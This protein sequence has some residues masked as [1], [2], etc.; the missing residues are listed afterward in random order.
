MNK[1]RKETW[2]DKRKDDAIMSGNVSKAFELAA[3][4]EDAIGCDIAEWNSDEIVSF[5][6]YYATS[7]IQ[8]LVNLHC[9]L[10]QY[11]DWCVENGLVTDNQNHWREIKTE[12]L[13]RCTD[14]GKVKSEIV[15]RD[16]LLERIK[17]LPNYSDMFI[18]LGLFEGIPF[19]DDCLINANIN[20]LNGNTLALSNGETRE[21][22]DELKRIMLIAS[23]QDKYISMGKFQ[24]EMDYLPIPGQII[25]PYNSKKGFSKKLKIAVTM[26]IRR[27]SEYMGLPEPMKIKELQ[28]SG[29]IDYI[30][31]MMNKYNIT[32][33]Q[34]IKETRYREEHQKIYGKIQNTVTYL[35][36]YG[37][38]VGDN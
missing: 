34:C 23:E 2:L 7:K 16:Q 27:C 30:K 8:S 10:R 9:Q 18:F 36:L 33:Q 21:I 25:R 38:L 4:I 19:K 37:W 35:A 12:T 13:L 20:D 28:E 3:K 14:I 1:Q 11:A 15:T 6:K 32:F 17:D 29:R 26:R 24:S 5:Y 31:K 22:S